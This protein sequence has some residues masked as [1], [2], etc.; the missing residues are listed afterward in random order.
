MASLDHHAE[1]RRAQG[2][3]LTLADAEA[4]PARWAPAPAPPGTPEHD[5][6]QSQA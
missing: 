4:G 1:S 3:A 5:G 2:G 6:T